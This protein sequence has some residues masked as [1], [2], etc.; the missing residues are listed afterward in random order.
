MTNTQRILR[1]WHP[2]PPRAG[3]LLRGD[4]ELAPY[5]PVMPETTRTASVTRTIAADPDTVW[6]MISDVGRMGEWSPETDRGEWVKGA[7]GPVPGAKFKGVNTLGKKSWATTCEVVEAEPGRSF[8]FRV[9]GGGLGVA[10]WE[11]RLEPAPEGC[12]VEERW[13]DE[14]GWLVTRLGK[15][16]SGVD[17][18]AEWNRAN[19]AET[20]D[21]LAAVAEAG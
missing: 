13:T 1:V 15:V 12:V 19:M 11:Y 4:W 20:L 5:A 8:C 7:D 18:D 2:R 3:V 17:H 14:R 21:R 6:A 16:I 10:L 9:S